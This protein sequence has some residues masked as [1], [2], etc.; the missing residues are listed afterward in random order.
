MNG[1]QF[2]STITVVVPLKGLHRQS[3]NENFK[4]SPRLICTEFYKLLIMYCDV[5]H[6]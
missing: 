5:K 6:C 2:S 3:T 1:V 4:K